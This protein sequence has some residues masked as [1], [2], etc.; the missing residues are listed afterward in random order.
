MNIVHV[1]DFFHPDAGYQINILPKYMTN[2]GHNVTIVTA[3]LKKIPE[4]L[5]SFFGKDNIKKRDDSYTDKTG[6]KI[7]RLP[8]K[9][10]ISGRAVFGKELDNTIESLNPD[11]LY[12][13][14]NDT[15]TGMRYINKLRKLK[16]PVVMDS[17]MLEM[18]STNKFSKLYK[19]FY[20]K[21]FTPKIKDYN[22]KIIRTQND[23]YV[24]KHLGIPIEQCP[25]IS[26]GSDTILFHP[27]EKVKKEFRKENNI[28]DDDFV[29]VYTGKLIES[30]GAKLLAQAF[31]KKL[32][33]S[34]NKKIVL[35]VVGNTSGEY[36]KE[37][38]KIFK[39]SQNRIIRFPT[40]KY[41]DLAK[42]YQASDLSV[43]PK[44]CSLSFYDA[45]ACGLPVVSE[46][47]TINVDRLKNNNGF[48]FELGDIDDFRE[49]IKK[50]VEMDDSKYQEMKN[51][52]INFV[53]ENYDYKDI[54]KQY[55]KILLDEYNRFNFG[56]IK[57]AN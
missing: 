20:R 13:H 9:A 52:A 38:E 18:A 3:E 1:E 54:S 30:K 29:V 53:K 40:Q 2:E 14:G 51:N 55:T 24:E 35:V 12:V 7:I 32:E 47:N 26:V 44:Q 21:F 56:G 50:C 27:D 57:N 6:V 33:N 17:H 25:W 31:E 5:T 43:F 4:E 10:F 22:L 16:Y 37:V 45:Q 23:S 42:F 49:K 28:S 15:L 36:G 19:Q 11:I 41:M 34:K 48:N 46:N 39:K 8:I